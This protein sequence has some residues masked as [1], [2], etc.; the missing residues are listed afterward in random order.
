MS[1][2]YAGY[3]LVFGVLGLYGYRL[4]IRTRQ[5]AAQVVAMGLDVD[6]PE[7]AAHPPEAA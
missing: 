1:Y 3:V 6:G 4:A 2:V 7:G 5:V